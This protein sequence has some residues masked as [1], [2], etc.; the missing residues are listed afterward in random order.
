[1]V[2]SSYAALNM[3][4][5]G[6]MAQLNDYIISRVDNNNFVKKETMPKHLGLHFFVEEKVFQGN[7]NGI[8]CPIQ[9][10]LC[11]RRSQTKLCQPVWMERS[12]RS[13][14]I[15]KAKVGVKMHSVICLDDFEIVLHKPAITGYL[16]F[17]RSY[18][19]VKKDVDPDVFHRWFLDKY[20]SF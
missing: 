19:V 3:I 6:S 16:I 5:S 4:E 15:R 11:D 12:Q 14:V 10:L 20:L 1:M 2:V 18:H 17:L 7:A 9:F 13:K 8:R